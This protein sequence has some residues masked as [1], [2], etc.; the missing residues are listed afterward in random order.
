MISLK[1]KKLLIKSSTRGNNVAQREEQSPNSEKRWEKKKKSP[2]QS[3]I[4]SL[5][6]SPPL[7]SSPSAHRPNGAAPLPPLPIRPI[8]WRGLVRRM[9]FL[10]YIHDIERFK[11]GALSYRTDGL[12]VPTKWTTQ[13][14]GDRELVTSNLQGR[15]LM[16]TDQR[17]V[18]CLMCC[19]ER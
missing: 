9:S 19:T 1:K 10:L 12:S 13:H 5:C 14:P 18:E 16:G 2:F 4:S 15:Q 7:L 8:S 6:C 11:A 17:E 3:P